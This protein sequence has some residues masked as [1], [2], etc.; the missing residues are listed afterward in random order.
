MLSKSILLK[1]VQNIN[2]VF[3]KLPGVIPRYLLCVCDICAQS[4]NEIFLL[5]ARHSV[6]GKN[7]CCEQGKSGKCPGRCLAGLSL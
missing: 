6:L 7:T 3:K 4:S 1:N 2:R 5:K